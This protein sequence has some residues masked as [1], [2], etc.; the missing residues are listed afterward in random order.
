MK[1]GQVAIRGSHQVGWGGTEDDAASDEVGRGGRGREM[2][3]SPFTRHRDAWYR[4]GRIGLGVERGTG[5]PFWGVKG[6]LRS[7]TAHQEGRECLVPYVYQG[8][9]GEVS[10]SCSPIKRG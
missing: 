7:H 6:V 9:A 5:A 8:T 10:Y 2:T 4:R 3:V 1:R